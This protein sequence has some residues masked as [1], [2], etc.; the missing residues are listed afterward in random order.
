MDED[1]AMRELDEMEFKD[2]EDDENIK[3]LI[4]S[5]NKV[6]KTIHIGEA[7]IRIKQYMPKKVR[8]EA[9]KA[10][11]ALEVATEENL[12]EAEN[13]L[14]P[15]VASMCIDKPFSKPETWKYIDEKTGCIQDVI[16]KIIAEV[17]KTDGDVK[18]FRRK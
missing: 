5:T 17:N 12:S 7:D 10:G 6:F 11:R 15:V 1:K 2:L 18:S 9:L 8:A 16:L 13:K 14:Y 4:A 3:S